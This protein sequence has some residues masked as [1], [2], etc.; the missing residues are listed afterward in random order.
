MI[1]NIFRRKRTRQTYQE[2]EAQVAIWLDERSKAEKIGL[3]NTRKGLWFKEDLYRA[4]L[5][6]NKKNPSLVAEYGGKYKKNGGNDES[7]LNIIERSTVTFS[8]QNFMEY[9]DFRG[10]NNTLAIYAI[11][12][13]SMETQGLSIA[14]AIY[15]KLSVDHIALSL[16]YGLW[17]A[18]S[19]NDTE[20]TQHIIKKIYQLE[21]PEVVA[22][23]FIEVL[24]LQNSGANYSEFIEVL[25]CEAQT[26]VA[27][28]ILQKNYNVFDK[29][30]LAVCFLRRG[31]NQ[32]Y[33]SIAKKIAASRWSVKDY[34]QAAQLYAVLLEVKQESVVAE[35]YIIS[36][37]RA[38]LVI[39][40]TLPLVDSIYKGY[41]AIKSTPKE[42][43]D[44]TW[45]VLYPNVLRKAVDEVVYTG[46]LKLAVSLCE[47]FS[48]E[49]PKKMHWIDLISIA[50]NGI[51]IPNQPVNLRAYNKKVS[52]LLYNSLPVHSGGYATRS[53]GIITNLMQKKIEPYVMTRLGYPYD[54][55][56]FQ[57]REKVAHET[58]DGITYHRLLDG[59]G[60]NFVPVLSYLDAYKNEVK[61]RLESNDV[62]IIHAASNHIN[63]IAAI[64]AGREL[65]IKT[66]FEVRGMWEITRLSRQ[67]EWEGSIEFDA[68]RYLETL[69]CE[70]ADA[71]ITITEALKL[72][73][74][75]RGVCADKINVVPNGVDTEIFTPM[76]VNHSLKSDLGIA[77]ED[78]VIGY[79]GSIVDYEGLD[80]LVESIELM[81]RNHVSNFKVLIIGDGVVLPELKQQV[82][83]AGL[84]EYFIFTGRI[85]HEQ[86]PDYYSVIDVCPFPR[87]GLPVCELVSP[88]KPFEA[89][90]MGK[91]IIGSSVKAI[92][93]F[94][95]EGKNG[96]VH[97]KD[98]S[99]DLANKL[100][101][102]VSDKELR[103]DIKQTSR[104]WAVE[105][106][107]WKVLSNKVYNV[108]QN[109]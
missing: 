93:E 68:Y 49:H 42:F 45:A 92:A 52:Y 66:I 98:D 76:E 12:A 62:S 78:T 27:T 96:F 103:E 9:F 80:L 29:E 109:L 13:L 34:L 67:P 97:E 65:G 59:P 61:K 48:F 75:S 90:A 100:T 46:Q 73:L 56:K 82:V 99:V 60:L 11:T 70:K 53:H 5:T 94:I 79:V 1:F 81:V 31:V 91:V 107:D 41:L 21:N 102:A 108:Y 105:N 84:T 20:L 35:R 36:C 51:E 26:S 85:P 32:K 7:I 18:V 58:Y 43:N 57:S 33:Y 55:N 83:D 2:V 30:K 87:R 3:R 23:A 16:P 38:E 77:K 86:V 19:S 63:G 39:N 28:K 106:R 4:L 15:F 8:V 88:L 69:A 95:D 72:E 17:V 64:L 14:K 74:I 71:V 104:D 47:R 44:S 50:E 101:K 10:V 22:N 89:M 6:L 25:I 24:A 54:L 37:L 40:C